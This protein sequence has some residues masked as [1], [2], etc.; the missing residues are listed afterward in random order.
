MNEIFKTQV[1]NFELSFKLKIT[2]IHS[3]KSKIYLNW[4]RK[5]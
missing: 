1:P 5:K 4:G 3:K 2:S